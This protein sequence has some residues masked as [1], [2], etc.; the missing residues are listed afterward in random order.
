MKNKLQK[1]FSLVALLTVIPIL[2]AGSTYTKPSIKEA[3]KKFHAQLKVSD[4]EGIYNDSSQR[5]QTKITK[6]EFIDKL[7]KDIEKLG[8]IKRI[9]YTGFPPP[10]PVSALAKDF[11]NKAEVYLIEGTKSA[12][13]EVLI[14]DVEEKQPKLAIYNT[15]FA[16]A[17]V[18]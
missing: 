16:A 1:M 3:A 2:I 10:N 11:K 4:F 18:Q 5:L 9:E 14:W 6:Q 13:Y 8:K 7:N 15:D 12:H 17:S